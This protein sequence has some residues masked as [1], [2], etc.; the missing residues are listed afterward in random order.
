[1]ETGKI[2]TFRARDP[3]PSEILQPLQHVTDKFPA[4]QNR[5]LK[6]ASTG[7]PAG[8]LGHV[9]SHYRRARFRPKLGEVRAKSSPAAPPTRLGPGPES[10]V[11][12]GGAGRGTGSSG[13]VG[14]AADPFGSHHGRPT[15]RR[16]RRNST[17]LDL[18]P[19]GALASRKKPA[20]TTSSR[21]D[22]GSIRY[23]DWVSLVS[24]P[25]AA[26]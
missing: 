14:T 5:D 1:M 8:T 2:G 9:Q 20:A 25:A 17:R 7:Q 4:D 24:V 13:A 12:G 23:S 22:A 21:T 16:P 19:S 15:S 18:R 10:A 3:V 11:T 26:A 6:S